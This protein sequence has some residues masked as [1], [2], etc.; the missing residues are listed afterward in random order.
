MFFKVKK[1][2][3]PVTL[4]DKRADNL[5]FSIML[6]KDFEAELF[7]CF[8][9]SKPAFETSPAHHRKINNLVKQALDFY[10][11]NVDEPHAFWKS[12]VVEGDDIAREVADEAARRDVD[13]IVMGVSRHPLLHT[14]L[15]SVTEKVCRTAPCPV[16]VTHHADS[17]SKNGNGKPRLRRILT[18]YDFSDYAEIALQAATALTEKYNAEF[19]LLQ[20]IDDATREAALN[21]LYHETIKRLKTVVTSDF[22][23]VSKVNI[24]ARWGKPYREILAYAAEQEID[25]IAMGAHGADFGS[26]TLFGSNVD[27]VLRQAPCAVL[28]ARP[29]KPSIG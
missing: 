17:D 1:I 3:C 27:R 15:G 20:V 5:S 2:L 14:I 12:I 7:V 8:C 28:V 25:L 18:A 21:G 29:R 24:A 19:H 22:Q 13:L 16:I 6:A 11:A 26:H 9:A 10:V 4:D 23:P